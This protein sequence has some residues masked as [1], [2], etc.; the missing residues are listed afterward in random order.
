MKNSQ[1]V[2]KVAEALN[3]IKGFECGY[4]T[5][6]F[7]EGYL[8]IEIDGVRFAVKM[9]KFVNQEMDLSKAVDQVKYNV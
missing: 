3:H 6:T 7:E 9:E 1:A 4:S 2:I 5:K 8:L